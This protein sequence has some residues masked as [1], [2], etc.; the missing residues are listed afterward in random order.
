MPPSHA[1]TRSG[2]VRI[3][4]LAYSQCVDTEA[5]RF[6]ISGYWD[7]M[8]V[9]QMR[10]GLCV[11]Q[12][13]IEGSRE[14]FEGSTPTAALVSAALAQGSIQYVNGLEV[15]APSF[16]AGL[17]HPARCCLMQSLQC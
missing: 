3:E 1:P 11:V 14:R 13:T 5:C 17:R 15:N 8:S 12:L 4:V 2:L 7:V 16:Q 9:E 10:M 6:C